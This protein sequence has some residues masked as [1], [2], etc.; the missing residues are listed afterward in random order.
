MSVAFTDTKLEIL[1]ITVKD[2]IT[3]DEKADGAGAGSDVEASNGA[4]AAAV[5]CSNLKYFPSCSRL[6]Q[7][8]GHLDPKN[9]VKDQQKQKNTIKQNK[10]KDQKKSSSLVVG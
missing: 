2:S 3:G 10:V 1:K 9:N 4:W 8:S 7:S 5:Q 6:E